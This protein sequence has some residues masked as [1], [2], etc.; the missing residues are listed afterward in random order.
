[1]VKVQSFR[2][3]SGPKRPSL[4]LNTEKIET[5]QEA[6]PVWTDS[7][8]KTPK[9]LRDFFH[10]D[11]VVTTESAGDSPIPS[12]G[13]SPV[14]KT[15]PRAP[16]CLEPYNL[17]TPSTDAYRGGSME[18]IGSVSNIMPYDATSTSAK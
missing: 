15:L 12:D 10:Q 11:I 18:S 14:R 1:M 6:T 5:P 17:S 16:Q 13:N 9:A 8:I 2:H 7:A 3:N 4:N